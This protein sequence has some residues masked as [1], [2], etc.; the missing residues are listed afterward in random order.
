MVIILIFSSVSCI[1]FLE[2]E[3]LY[4]PVI[5]FCWDPFSFQYLVWVFV[6][7]FFFHF[8][9]SATLLCAVS[10]NMSYLYPWC[11][12]SST[13]IISD[14]RF[15]EQWMSYSLRMV[16]HSKAL[17]W[18]VKSCYSKQ[19]NSIEILP[20]LIFS[21]TTI[22]IL[23]KIAPRTETGTKNVPT[24][25]HKHTQT[26]THTHTWPIKWI[27]ISETHKM[28]SACVFMMWRH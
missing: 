7:F 27:L 6:E 10:H 2:T 4:L 19:C 22:S 24:Y 13:E 28:S 14:V 3:W 5:E 23:L 18:F 26:H 17:L 16:K 12:C 9:G 11:F 25:T 21:C 15:Q 20:I 8:H 1:L